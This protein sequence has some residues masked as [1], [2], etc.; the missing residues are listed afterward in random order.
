M[1]LLRTHGWRIALVASGIT[2]LVGGPM[3]PEADAEGTLTEELATMTADPSWVPAHS[4][5]VV[6]TVLLAVGLTTAYRRKAWPTA[7]K[8]L[9]F[10]VVAV[11]LYVV[12]TFFHLASAVDSHALH[13]GDAAPVA[14]THVGLSVVLYPIAG[15]AIAYLAG[16]QVAT[17]RGARRITGL[18]GVVGGLLHAMSVPLT[19]ALPDAEMTPVF[20]GSA[21]LLAIWALVTGLAGAPRPTEVPVAPRPLTV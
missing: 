7:H 3:H 20:A 15:I 11:C 13:H 9:G 8:A 12:E 19:L 2:M 10:A 21:V 6:S 16:R 17:W 14:F 4:L 18:P 5:I 1:R